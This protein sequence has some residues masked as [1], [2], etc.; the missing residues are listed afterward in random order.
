MTTMPYEWNH[1]TVTPHTTIREA[2]LNLDQS[3]MQIVLVADAS[4]R[5]L[6]TVT[7]GDLRRALLRGATLESPVQQAMNREPCVGWQ[8]ESPLVWRQRMQ[9]NSLR[10]LPVLDRDRRL[11]DLIHDRPEGPVQWSNPV[12]LM[13]GGLGM[14]LRP[15]TQKVPKPMLMVG[16]KPILE[17]ILEHVAEQGFSH[18]Y[19]CINYLGEMIQDHFGDGSRWGVQIEYIEEKQRMGTAGALGLLEKPLEEDFL[20]MNGDLLTKVD[21][22]ALLSFHQEHRHEATVCV[23]EHQQQVP[24]G[25]MEMGGT[26][27]TQLV[28]KPVYRYFVNAGIYALSPRT[29]QHVPK[30]RPYDMPQLLNRLIMQ[31]QAVGGFPLTEYW[32]DIGQLPDF[33]QA[34]ADFDLHFTRIA[35]EEKAYA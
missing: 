18:F 19:F 6:G 24:Y 35:P 8:Q 25:V 15:L 32:L 5:L 1:I 26:R 29:L 11:V 28:E 34:Q 22:G 30:N 21:L 10:H 12:V 3:S 14:R 31:Q 4:G 27:I 20:V 7:D 23:R 9:R 17:T 2:L 16:D 13:L 33:K